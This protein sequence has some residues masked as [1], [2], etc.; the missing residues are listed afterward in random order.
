M[1]ELFTKES[2]REKHRMKIKEILQQG[3][4]VDEIVTCIM[5][6]ISDVISYERRKNERRALRE[7]SKNYETKKHK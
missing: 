6:R 5:S 4:G 2:I 3:G 1:A 7:W